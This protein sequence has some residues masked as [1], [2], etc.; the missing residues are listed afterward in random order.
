MPTRTRRSPASICAALITSAELEFA[1]HGFDAA[2]TRTIAE[3]AGAHQPQINYHFS[4]KEQLW[5]D[6][7][8]QLFGELDATVFGGSV[9]NADSATVAVLLARFLRFSAERPALNR[10][11]NLEASAHS[12]RLDWLLE[13]HLAPHFELVA[14]AWESLRSE[15]GGADLTPEEVWEIITSFGALHFANAPMLSQL[16][17]GHAITADQQIDRTLRLLGLRAV[18]EPPLSDDD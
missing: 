8:D 1:T 6:T 4:S 7:V 5:K 14:A 12:A 13:T 2:S 16:G 3:R 15:G 17:E 10:I 11:V 9:V 18:C